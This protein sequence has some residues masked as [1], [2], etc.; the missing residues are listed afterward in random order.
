MPAPM[1][2]KTWEKLR[3]AFLAGKNAQEAGRAANV[4]KSTAWRAWENGVGGRPAIKDLV[5]DAQAATS[6]IVAEV[7]RQAGPRVLE[8]LP[9]PAAADALVAHIGTAIEREFARAHEAAA[10]KSAHN[11][12]TRL[13]RSLED[14]ANKIEI[15]MPGAA[16][17]ILEALQAGELKP[18]DAVALL[19][20]LSAIAQRTMTLF[21]AQQAALRTHTSDLGKLEEPVAPRSKAASA[22]TFQRAKRAAERAARRGSTALEVIEGGAGGAEHP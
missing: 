3:D 9:S 14:F 6:P 18:A 20:R 19:D 12:T 16:D 10:L 17:S 2:Q 21:T 15:V 4:S 22:E 1:P 5:A 7:V 13:M 8:A 11:I